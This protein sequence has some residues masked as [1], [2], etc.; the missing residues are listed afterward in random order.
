LPGCVIFEGLLDIYAKL[1]VND[2]PAA[3]ATA[4]ERRLLPTSWNS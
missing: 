1:N 3:V 4:F 2:R